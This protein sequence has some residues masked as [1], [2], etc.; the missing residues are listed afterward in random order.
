[1]NGEPVAREALGQY[2]SLH[3]DSLATLY[4]ESLD[5]GEYH[6]LLHERSPSGELHEVTVPDDMYFTLGDNRDRSADSR[7]WGFV[8]DDYLVGRAFLIWMSWDV[9][10]NRVDWG[11]IGERIQ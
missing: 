2:D 9:H 3:A 11:R 4:Q 10:N 8:P 5:A 1:M 6:V 7:M